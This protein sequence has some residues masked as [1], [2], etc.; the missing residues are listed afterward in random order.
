MLETIVSVPE[1]LTTDHRIAEAQANA[2]AVL[3]VVEAMDAATTVKEAIEVTLDATRTAFGWAYGSYWALDE[4]TRALHF[5]QES[6]T[7][8]AEFREVTMNAS[9]KEGTGLS[10]RAWRTRELVF[11]SDLGTVTDCVRAPVAQRAGVKSGVC[12]PIIVGS[13]VIGTMDF[14]ATETLTLTDERLDALR[15]IGRVVSSSFERLAAGE[16]QLEAAANTSAINQVLGA[17]SAARSTEEA[18]KSA[19]ETVR[20]SFG[21]A[22]GSFW[23]LDEADRALKFKSQS[24]TVNPEFQRVTEEAS[25]REGEGL[26][27]RT[28]KT[29][30]LV[31]VADLGT[32]LDCV[33]APVAQRA[34]VKSGVCFPIIVNSR[35]IATMDFFATETLT[36]SQERLDALRNVGRLVSTTFER[37]TDAERQAENSTNTDAVNQVL[38]ALS[39]A[40]TTSEAVQVALDTVRT[41]FGW[42][43]GSFWTLDEADRALRFE[44]QSGTV[45]P[46]FQRVTVEARFREGEGLSGRA[47]KTR[48]LF[49]VSDIGTM[50]DC[51]R[52]PVAQRAG[53][54]S[55]VC[56]PII[57]EGRVTGTMDFFATRTLTL[58]TE[59]L[60]ALRNVGRLVSAAV[61][62]ITGVMRLAQM[63][64]GI[65]QNV[66]GL[67]GT[68]NSLTDLALG[69][70]S[71]SEEN[72]QQAG[73]TAATAEQTSR[74]VQTV[75]TASEELSISIREI[76][77]SVQDSSRLTM[78]SVSLAKEANA[79]ITQLGESSQEIGKV[80]KLITSIAQQTNLL[81][82]NAT[83]E[84]ARAGEAG[85]GFAVVAS[86][87]KELAKETARATEDI[88]TKIEAIQRDTQRAVDAI[89]RISESIGRIN[90]I[91]VT[92]SSAVEEQAVTTQEITRNMTE[93]AAGTSDVVRNISAVADASKESSNQ[94]SSVL[95]ASKRLTE[96]SASL[97]GLVSA[98][99]HKG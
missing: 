69:L 91:S 1:A 78:D 9:F 44:T 92:I 34:G 14:F 63:V 66:S 77:K 17:M 80:V 85:R 53:V 50:T 23:S 29:R 68:A 65:E 33:R 98:Y 18:V 73:V 81:A 62:R 43:Y 71:I 20:S 99:Q 70:S 25:F 38:G 13:R 87:V 94:A 41:A 76:A 31:F 19:L 39:A 22:Y 74:N 79:S 35:V 52:A 83:I 54:K 51:V 49:F 36:L 11:V 24:G 93:A 72:N 32:V 8:N 95:D 61:E 88:G 42:A 55:G 16:R 90:E 82:L 26:S 10:G 37:L 30:E 48:D 28:W 46:E 59:R 67:V 7:V 45:N 15:G 2:R 40:S 6:G 12:F 96:L 60:D 4:S 97:G 56:F 75:A 84:A 89:V 21:W 3:T 5:V 57:V 58:S 64:S 27:G 47:W 86:E